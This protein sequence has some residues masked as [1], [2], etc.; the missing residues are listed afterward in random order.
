MLTL[1]FDQFTHFVL[2]ITSNLGYWGIFILMT[3]E[4]TIIPFPSEII[5]IPAGVVVAQGGLS[6]TLVLLAATLGSVAGALINY[7]L[8]LHLGRRAVNALL[9]RYE[10]ILFIN[11]SHIVKAEQSFQR[12]GELATFVGRL[13]PA[14]RS[15]IS[16]PAGFTRMNVAR[17]CIFTA[18]GAGLWSA[19]LIF[20]GAKLGENLELIRSYVSQ[21]VLV[22]VILLVPIILVYWHWHTRHRLRNVVAPRK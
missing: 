13:I 18:L 9:H 21:I 2:S 17:F 19:L 10:R 20:L 14:L 5:L 3:I 8:A 22:T 6:F 7:A 4:S 15:F 1:L 11:Y 16:L 12:H